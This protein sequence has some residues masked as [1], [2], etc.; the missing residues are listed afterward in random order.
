[1]IMKKT[2]GNTLLNIAAVIGLIVGVWFAASWVDIV[3]DNC[4]P[5]PVH[6]KWNM[7]C[8]GTGYGQEEIVEEPAEVSADYDTHN[9]LRIEWAEVLNTEG[10]FVT[11]ITEDGN[12]WTAEVGYPEQFD[13][14][15]FYCVYFD[16]MDTEDIF[17]DEILKVFV[18][19][20]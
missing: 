1:M 8:F 4:E 15:R 18:E 5:N 9:G 13:N 6:A 17:D 2:I 7:F 11:F 3:A 19:I 16:M 20:W 10:N 12:A 14:N